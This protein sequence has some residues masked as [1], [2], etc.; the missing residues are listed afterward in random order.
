M[1]RLHRLMVFLATFE[2][3]AQQY[4]GHSLLCLHA[5][6]GSIHIFDSNSSKANA[7]KFYVIRTYIWHPRQLEDPQALWVQGAPS[8]APGSYVKRT[9]VR[10]NWIQVA[11][12][13]GSLRLNWIEVAQERG[14]LRLNWIQVAHER[15]N[16]RLNWIQVAQE[17]GK[18]GLL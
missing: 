9:V 6:A 1:Q 7:P 16:L 17:R 11:Q 10:L 18:L 14:N 3:I 8:G 2:C 4:K 15:G 13:R 5:C 12:E